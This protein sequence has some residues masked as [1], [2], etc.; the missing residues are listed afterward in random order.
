MKD[1]AVK[2]I[3]QR[4]ASFGSDTVCEHCY[5]VVPD[6]GDAAFDDHLPLVRALFVPELPFR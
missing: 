4:D 3:I 5:L 2:P 1:I 6:L